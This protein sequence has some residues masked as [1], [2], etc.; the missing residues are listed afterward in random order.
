[1][2][3]NFLVSSNGVLR[4]FRVHTLITAIF[5]NYDFS[6]LLSNLFSIY[7]AF[8]IGGSARFAAMYLAGGLLSTG[9][10]VV[11]FNR[12]YESTSGEVES[13]H[14]CINGPQF[15]NDKTTTSKF[16]VGAVKCVYHRSE[17]CGWNCFRLQ[18]LDRSK[19]DYS[20]V[21]YCTRKSRFNRYVRV[22]N[23]S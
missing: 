9:S 1:M 4:H 7:L 10:Q 2:K 21:R 12:E 17:L 20:F 22:I 13:A 15:L 6:H 14:L 16:T 11:M 23:F 3:E 19:D 18:S 5:F 8:S